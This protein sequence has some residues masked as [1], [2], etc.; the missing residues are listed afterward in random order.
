MSSNTTAA[1]RTQST[2]R[3]S[4]SPLRRP[5]TTGVLAF[6]KRQR[7]SYP[8][9]TASGDSSSPFWRTGTTHQPAARQRDVD[10]DAACCSPPHTGVP[11]RQP[12]SS[13]E[14]DPGRTHDVADPLGLGVDSSREPV[15]ALTEMKTSTLEN[16]LTKLLMSEQIHRQTKNGKEVRG[17]DGLGPA[18]QND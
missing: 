6:L 12:P 7:R 13:A 4:P 3:A 11:S 2:E 10:E 17:Y 18:P 5:R 14:D 8:A 9:T 1:A 16:T 15:T